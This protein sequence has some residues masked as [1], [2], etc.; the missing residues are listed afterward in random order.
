MKTSACICD[1][2]CLCVSL[3][4]HLCT[5]KKSKSLLSPLPFTDTNSTIMWEVHTHTH[6]GE[7]RDWAAEL[8]YRY[9][10]NA[11]T[12]SIHLIVLSW[13]ISGMWLLTL[14]QVCEKF[15]EKV[16]KKQGGLSEAVWWTATKPRVKRWTITVWL[17]SIW[18]RRRVVT[19]PRRL[20]FLS[21]F[22]QFLSLSLAPFPSTMERFW[23]RNC[24]TLEVICRLLLPG[25]SACL[26]VLEY[27][28]FFPSFSVYIWSQLQHLCLSLVCAREIN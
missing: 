20:H 2:P 13:Q 8:Y 4:T 3:L 19:S 27:F 5:Q 7:E 25:L 15:P 12:S 21:M 24:V 28:F 22:P 1:R 11:Y 17:R 14:G 10:R 26:P 6:A 18:Q 16:H 9:S 23:K